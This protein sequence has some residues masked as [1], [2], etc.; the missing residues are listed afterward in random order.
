MFIIILWALFSARLIY[1]AVGYLSPKLFHSGPLTVALSVLAVFS[2]V[3]L[4]ARV[5]DGWPES[6][7]SRAG[8]SSLIFMASAAVM[9][10]PLFYLLWPILVMLNSIGL[11]AC[12]ALFTIPCVL[13]LFPR[14]D[15]V[16]DYKVVNH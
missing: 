10:L 14:K 3:W 6:F 12:L 15:R 4:G 5:Y 9:A 2:G 11:L 16:D 1:S 13:R 8:R 7:R